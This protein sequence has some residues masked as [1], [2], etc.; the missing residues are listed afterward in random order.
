M[1]YS[2]IERDDLA[3]SFAC[4]L[5]YTHIPKLERK[6]ERERERERDALEVGSLFTAHMNH[7]Y[8]EIKLMQR[9]DICSQIFFF[10]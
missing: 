9:S 5:R 4:K 7:G 3:S 10:L 2:R 6:R 8:A 1:G